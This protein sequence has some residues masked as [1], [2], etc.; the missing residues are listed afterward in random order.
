[1]LSI[2]R[3]LILV[4]VIQVIHLKIKS[5][6]HHLLEE[7]WRQNQSKM[8]LKMGNSN[9]LNIL[10]RIGLYQWQGDS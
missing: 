7:I 4:Q 5:A 8:E 9:I 10:N 2:N 3:N 6:T 1:L